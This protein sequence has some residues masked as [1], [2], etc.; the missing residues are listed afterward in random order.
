V[1]EGTD[2]TGGFLKFPGGADE[3]GSVLGITRT[4]QPDQDDVINLSPCRLLPGRAGQ[5][6]DG[7]VERR[8]F[9]PI[10]EVEV[11]PFGRV[12]D[13]AVFSHD[14]LKQ[15]AIAPLLGRAAPVVA[16]GPF[17]EIIEVAPRDGLQNEKTILSI[18]NKLRLIKKIESC[19]FTDIEVGS[20]VNPKLVPQMKGSGDLVRFLNNKINY[21][22]SF[23][24]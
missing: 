4:V 2:K 5:R 12:A 16:V 1:A 20:I 21:F 6:L 19:G 10:L 7:D 13:E 18:G 9:L 22:K 23:L 17:A 8:V 11:P 15:F 24:K 14:V 3:G